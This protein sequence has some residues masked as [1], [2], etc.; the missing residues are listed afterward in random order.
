MYSGLSYVVRTLEFVID[1]Q[2]GLSEVLRILEF[3]VKKKKR[4]LEFD[5]HVYS[6]LRI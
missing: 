1:V 3:L 6:G 4:T 5:L 2:Y